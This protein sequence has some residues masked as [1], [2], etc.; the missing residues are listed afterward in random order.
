VTDAPRLARLRQEYASLYPGLEPGLWQDAEE[1]AEWLL[2]E[3]LCDPALGL[4]CA[5][6]CFPRNISNPR[7]GWSHL[8][9]FL[10]ESL[11]VSHSV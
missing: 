3:H 8:N 5:P 11:T 4:C 7:R 10:E 6:E 1:L 9:A 2:A